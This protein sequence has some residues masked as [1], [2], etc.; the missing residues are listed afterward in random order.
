MRHYLKADKIFRCFS[1][2]EILHFKDR[3]RAERGWRIRQLNKGDRT[4]NK[5][6]EEQQVNDI[7][8]IEKWESFRDEHKGD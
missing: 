3:E 2:V 4:G 7:W 5:R 6:V 8:F 1:F